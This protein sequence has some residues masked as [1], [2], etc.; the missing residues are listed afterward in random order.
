MGS[1]Q[2][3]VMK[4]SPCKGVSASVV[5]LPAGI[6]LPRKRKGNS[7]IF[8]LKADSRH[9]T[10]C[11]C[12]STMS[13]TRGSLHSSQRL[14]HRIFLLSSMRPPPLSPKSFIEDARDAT[15]SGWLL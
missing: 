2:S 3:N 4:A 10:L 6:W 9:G 1:A 7:M 14:M 11:W 13:K 5:V 8:S 15:M 12:F